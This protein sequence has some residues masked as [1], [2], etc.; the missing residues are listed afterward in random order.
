M[1]LVQFSNGTEVSS[2]GGKIRAGASVHRKTAV[3]EP[4]AGT[5]ETPL[6]LSGQADYLPGDCLSASNHI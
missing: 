2:A 5:A 6:N 4:I 3:K 1:A